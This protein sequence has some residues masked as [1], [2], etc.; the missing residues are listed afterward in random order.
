MFSI[1]NNIEVLRHFIANCRNEH[2][3]TFCCTRAYSTNAVYIT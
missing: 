2:I 1:F 3:G